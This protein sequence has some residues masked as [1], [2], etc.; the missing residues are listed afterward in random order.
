MNTSP[1]GGPTSSKDGGHRPFAGKVALVT[2]ASSGLGEAAALAL[3]ERGAKVVLAARRSDRCQA[4][5]G[6]IRAAGGEAWA[7]QAD[8][9][10]AADVA[11]MI[12]AALDRFGR[13]DCAVNN[14]GIAGPMRTPLAEVEEA[15]WDAVMEVNLKGVWLCMKHEIPA[16]LAGGGGAIVNVASIYGLKPSDVGHSAYAAS[17]H[18]VV[19]L[20]RSAASDYGQQALRI[21]A[22]APG[23]TRSEMVDTGRPGAAEH[24]ARMVARHGGMRRLGEA[25]EAANAIA[26]LCSDEAGYVNGAV[27]EVDG[28]G[29]TR[30]Y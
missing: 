23:Y 3:A 26:W 24:Y 13:L 21:N 7:V 12:A 30:M 14:A 25:R 5:A 19:G 20:T 4:L 15:Q 1:A 2:G 22:V 8:V 16:M 18:G 17:K 27:L 11:A 28:G 29:A 10:R 6:R 9:S